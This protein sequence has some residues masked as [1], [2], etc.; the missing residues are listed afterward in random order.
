MLQWNTVGELA[1]RLSPQYGDGELDIFGVVEGTLVAL[2][3]GRTWIR[4]RKA[5]AGHLPPDLIVPTS[6]VSG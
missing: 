2:S 6:S 1:P 5:D 4:L 3:R